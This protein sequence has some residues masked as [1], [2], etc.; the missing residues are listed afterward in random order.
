MS[1]GGQRGARMRSAART[2]SETPLCQFAAP[3]RHGPRPPGS[4]PGD[5]NPAR[6]PSHDGFSM[7]GCDR[8]AWMD[9]G[10][11]WHIKD[12][13]WAPQHRLCLPRRTFCG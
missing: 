11:V 1:H 13:G 6:R 7:A 10:T 5:S 8:Q 4:R 2:T 12:H 9:R 3:S